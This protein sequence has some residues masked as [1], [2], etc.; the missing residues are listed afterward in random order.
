M[1]GAERIIE[2][3]QKKGVK[4]A[5]GY[6]GGPIIVLYDEIGRAHV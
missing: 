1:N 6:P 5:F 3:L 2:F 4:H